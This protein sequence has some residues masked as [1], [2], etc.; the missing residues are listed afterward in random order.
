MTVYDMGVGGKPNDDRTP[1][2][3]NSVCRLNVIGVSKIMKV[4]N[5]FG[6]RGAYL[7]PNT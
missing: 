5:D 4:D 1:Y 6:G 3:I 7:Q 2:K